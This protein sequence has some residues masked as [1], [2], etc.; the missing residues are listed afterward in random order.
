MLCTVSPLA[1]AQETQPG[2]ACLAGEEG[3]FR[4][5]AIDVPGPAITGQNFMYCNGANW[6]SFMSYNNTDSYTTLGESFYFINSGQALP[7]NMD[8]DGTRLFFYVDKA[9][10]RGGEI[11]LS[12]VAWQDTNIGTHS[13][14]WGLNARASGVSSVALGHGSEAN[15]LNSVALGYYAQV[16]GGDSVAIGRYAR[17]DAQRSVSIGYYS[18]AYGLK[19]VAIGNYPYAMAARSVVIGNYAEASAT[20]SRSIAIGNYTEADGFKSAA[21]GSYA[22][23][24]GTKSLALGSYSFTAADAQ[25]S[26]AVGSYTEARGVNSL[27]VGNNVIARGVNSAAIGSNVTVGDGT[28]TSGDRSMALGLGFGTP[29]PTITGQ[30]SLG[31]FMGDQSGVDLTTDNVMVLMG[32]N[33]GIKKLAPTVELDVVGDI[34]FTGTITDV[35]DRRLKTDIQDISESQLQKLLMLNG[36]TFHMKDRPEGPLE[37]GFIAQDVQTIYPSLVFQHGDDDTL[38]MNYVGLIAPIIEAMQEQNTLIEKQNTLIERLEARI[39]ALEAAQN[40]HHSP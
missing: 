5:S 40:E 10:F 30:H 13:F 39:E 15:T 37:Y 26:A 18:G 38:S 22:N 29:L 16:N 25:Q 21:V 12:D 36:V 11:T 35:S 27:A 4:R 24:Q 14:A 9:A 23:S 34:Q 32:G 31:I 7:A 2:D 28:A 17:G 19:S 8:D 6:V 33:M 20:A 1:L 3:H